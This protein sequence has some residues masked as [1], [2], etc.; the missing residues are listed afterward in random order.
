MVGPRGEATDRR[1]VTAQRRSMGVIAHGWHGGD[2]DSLW[3]GIKCMAPSCR[4]GTW[5][6]VSTC[7]GSKP[8]SPGHA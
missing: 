2:L 1:R 4:G 7:H 6:L 3:C 5:E 8:M